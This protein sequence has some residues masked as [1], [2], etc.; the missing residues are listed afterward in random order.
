MERARQ[1]LTGRPEKAQK[2]EFGDFARNCDGGSLQYSIFKT[3]FI[4]ACRREI[5]NIQH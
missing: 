2:K 3:P 4:C 1:R 5:L